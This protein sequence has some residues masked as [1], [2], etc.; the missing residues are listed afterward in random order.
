[1]I[2]ESRI[3]TTKNLA[4]ALSD[5]RVDE[6]TLISTSA[7]GYYGFRGDEE[8]DETGGAGNDFLATVAREWEE[9]AFEA[10]KAG[11]RVL[12][13][14]LGIVPGRNG[15]ALGEMIPLFQKGLGSRLGD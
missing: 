9:A 5:R 14:R 7:V 13:C 10:E 2:R 15:G 4:H 6:T 3:L 1:M 8:L 12:L 11:V